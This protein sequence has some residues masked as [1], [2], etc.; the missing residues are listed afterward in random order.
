MNKINTLRAQLR[1]DRKWNP[2]WS[3]DERMDGFHFYFHRGMLTCEWKCNSLGGAVSLIAVEYCPHYS[4]VRL[5]KL[6]IKQLFHFHLNPFA[7]MLNPANSHPFFYALLWGSRD[8]HHKDL[9]NGWNEAVPFT[10]PTKL[11]A[12]NTKQSM[13]KCHKKVIY[14][15]IKY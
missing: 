4:M 7:Q 2:H 9:K 10:T 13:W 15:A 8:E 11:D 5:W 1:T 14:F 3:L 12:I 6:N